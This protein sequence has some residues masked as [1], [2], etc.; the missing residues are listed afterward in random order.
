MF[1]QKS[2]QIQ[3]DSVLNQVC[4][5]F[6]TDDNNEGDSN[7]PQ[8]IS[9]KRWGSR[10]AKSI[11]YQTIPVKYVIVHHTVTPSCSTKLKCSNILLGIQNYHMDQQGGED[12]PYK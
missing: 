5:F 4:S 6:V 7:C 8:I 12:I 3:Y 2:I 11:T 10:V 1:V 9:R